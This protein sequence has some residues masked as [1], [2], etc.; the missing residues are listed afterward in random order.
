MPESVTQH[1]APCRECP[2]RR[3][4]ARGWLGS[5]TADEWLSHAHGETILQC[6]IIGGCQC[7]GA[8]IYRRNVAKLPRPPALI[9][10]ADPALC[11]SSRAEFKAHHTLSKP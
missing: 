11:F 2:W 5:L 1:K 4:A 6:H 10:P 7:A 8:A 9:L 3:A